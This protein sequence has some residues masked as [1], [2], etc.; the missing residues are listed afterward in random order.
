MMIHLNETDSTN[1]YL[2][3][4][5]QGA[6]NNKIEEFTTICADYQTAGKGQRGNSW[7][8]AKGANLLFSFVCYPTF[9]PI[10]QQFVLS[11]LISL[12]IKETLDEY[13][14]DISIKWPNDIYWKEKK[15]C[16]IL[17]ENDLQGNSIGRCISGIGLNINQ[18]VFLSDAPNPISLKQITGKHYQRETILEKVMQRIEQSYQKLKEDSAYASE[19]ATRYAASLFRREGLH[20]YQDKDGLFNARLVRVE[21]DGRFVLMDEANQERSYL[22]KEVQYVL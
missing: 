15:I 17:I 16:G 3:Q 12:G 9:V 1:R 6:G 2:Q 18:E 4:L 7:E 5:C 13:C 14:S 19:L 8:A 10:R 20:C 11:Q 22:F 21:A